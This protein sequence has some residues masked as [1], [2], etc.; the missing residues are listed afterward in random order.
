MAR[1]RDLPGAAPAVGAF[2]LTV[3]LGVGGASAS[4]L[5]QQGATATMTVTASGT[6]PPPVFNTPVCSNVDNANK[7]VSLAYSGFSEAPTKLTFSAAGT[8]GVYGATS[9]LAGPFGT[10][11]NVSLFGDS[12]IFTQ[13][14]TTPATVR[15]VATFAGGAQAT[16][17]VKV[18]L[19]IGTG[20]KKIYCA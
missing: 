15:I 20:N 5:W 2:V 7:Y 16:A 13:I 12:A 9:D 3:L 8:N 14:T 19:E 18:S 6:W 11:G 10:S 1:F 17:Y 4:A